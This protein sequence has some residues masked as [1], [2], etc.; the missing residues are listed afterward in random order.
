VEW[1][2]RL[3]YELRR[4]KSR[5]RLHEISARQARRRRTTEGIG[6]KVTFQD[7]PGPST[8]FRTPSVRL[9]GL[10]AG[11]QSPQV[12]S[13][14]SERQSLRQSAWAEA[15]PKSRVQSPRSKALLD[16]WIIRFMD[17]WEKLGV[18]FGCKGANARTPRGPRWLPARRIN[19]FLF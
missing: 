11:V 19:F 6:R 9:P 16:S 4:G 3:R 14:K 15:S 12:Q 7:L 8:T 17:G 13:P 5:T 10:G 18:G 2:T 1:W